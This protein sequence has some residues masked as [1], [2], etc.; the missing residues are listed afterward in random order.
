[1]DITIIEADEQLAKAKVDPPKIM[2]QTLIK[3]DKPI[4]NA[5]DIRS[6]IYQ[7]KVKDAPDQAPI[8]LPR[9][10]YQRVI[11]DDEHTAAVVLD[12]DQPVNAVDD[13]PGEAELARSNMID[14]DDPAVTA[15]LKQA[16]AGLAEDASDYEVATRL[17]AFVHE[18][19]E[20]KN[21]SVGLATAG[22]VA[23]TMQG[24][25]T[26][27]GVLL[28]A[29][30]RAKGIPSRTVTGLIYVDQ[31]LGQQGVFGY[32]MWS[33]AWLTVDVDG[34]AAGGRWVDLDATLPGKNFDA[35]HITLSV[36]AMADGQMGNDLVQIVPLFGRLEI[37]VKE[38]H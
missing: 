5:R 24:D 15:L 36:S 27:H 13:L 22:Q 1:M 6:A 17:R 30:L 18:Y 9:T 20:A 33:Q 37:Q 14:H 16:L 3:P 8:E 19:I 2:A 23:R 12:L 34:E 32:H 7:V 21:L 11:W 35:A 31:F 29:L 4:E 28:T 25:C 10:G 26:E 38:A